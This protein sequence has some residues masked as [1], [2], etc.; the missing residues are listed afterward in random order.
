MLQNKA[1]DYTMDKDL[2]KTEKGKKKRI[3]QTAE[4][5]FLRFQFKKIRDKID[6]ILHSSKNARGWFYN[7]VIKLKKGVY[8]KQGVYL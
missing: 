3:N 5:R 6:T 1:R 7:I 8:Q 4:I 2:L